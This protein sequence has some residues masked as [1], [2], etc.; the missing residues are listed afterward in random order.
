MVNNKRGSAV[1]A[2][3]QPALKLVYSETVV[4]PKTLSLLTI[5][6]VA[7]I[8]ETLNSTVTLGILI[9]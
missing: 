8:F 2:G 1:L 6:V 9:F 5:T 4:S 3:S 7:Q